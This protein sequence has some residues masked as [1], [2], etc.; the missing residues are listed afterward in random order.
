M[1][2]ATYLNPQKSS[3]WSNG[4][5]LPEMEEIVQRH[6]RAEATS[7]REVKGILNALNFDVLYSIMVLLSRRDLLCL[8]R[9]CQDLHS[10]CMK[11]LLRSDIQLKDPPIISRFCTYVLNDPHTRGPLLRSI[12]VSLDWIHII[13]K[14]E[15]SPLCS[16][17]MHACN[18]KKLAILHTQILHSLQPDLL[19]AALSSLSSLEVF[20][21]RGA[22]VL[23]PAVVRNM[24]S[25]LTH[26]TLN[27][28]GQASWADADTGMLAFCLPTLQTLHLTASLPHVPKP[29]RF[30]AL[31]DLTL[32]RPAPVPEIVTL[33]RE[34]PALRAVRFQTPPVP[35]PAAESARERYAAEH[36]QLSWPCLAHVAADLAGLYQV[37]LRQRTRRVDVVVGALGAHTGVWAA[38]VLADMQPAH[39]QLK[40]QVAAEHELVLL[41]ELLRAATQLRV[42]KLIFAPGQ[43]IGPDVVVAMVRLL[44]VVRLEIVELV[45]QNTHTP[46]SFALAM[47]AAVPSIRFI[48]V[49]SL[50]RTQSFSIMRGEPP[51]NAIVELITDPYPEI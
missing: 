45:G 35:A 28:D 39:I 6:I 38:A 48:S 34:C 37:A 27:W 1:F 14:E 29:P 13:R 25:P 18:L 43:P 19:A 12:S 24:R 33:L 41:P 30:P 49:S 4:S 2:R 7:S 40:V 17:L 9:T 20:E 16:V 15:I 46:E 42:L 51:E 36:A 26:L 22:H 8:M 50:K 21:V 10:E 32:T 44:S 23:N 11:L 47:A 31:R 3:S 5:E